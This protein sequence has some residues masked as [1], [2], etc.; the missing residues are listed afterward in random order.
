MASDILVILPSEIWG[1]C[2]TYACRGDRYAANLLLFTSV[3][4]LWFQLLTEMPTLWTNIHVDDSQEDCLATI[5]IFLHLSREAGLSLTVTAPLPKSWSDT[6][7]MVVS[8]RK[9]VRKIS[10]NTNI[11]SHSVGC[12]LR[13]ATADKEAQWTLQHVLKSLSFPPSIRYLDV[14]LGRPCSMGSVWTPP[15]LVSAGNWLL[16]SRVLASQPTTCSSLGALSIRATDLVNIFSFLSSLGQLQR[17][18]LYSEKEDYLLPPPLPVNLQTARMPS[19]RTLRYHGKLH[20]ASSWLLEAASRTVEYLELHI[21]ILDIKIAI[22]SLKKY[23]SLHQLSLTLLLLEYDMNDQNK[24]RTYTQRG[25][26]NSTSRVKPPQWQLKQVQSFHCILRTFSNIKVPDS[27][28]LDHLWHLFQTMFPKMRDLI[29]NLPVQS[30]S[31]FLSL[32]RQKQ[33]RHFE[34]NA[35]ILPLSRQATGFTLGALETL[36]VESI[37][38]LHGLAS[39]NVLYLSTSSSGIFEIPAGVTFMRLRSMH[40]DIRGDTKSSI[41][42][43]GGEFPALK[44]FSIT[45][46]GPTSELIVADFSSLTEISVST[47]LPTFTQGMKFCVALMC[48]PWKCPRLE[49]VNLDSFLEYDVLYMLLLKRNCTRTRAKVS[50]IKRLRLSFLLRIL[51]QTFASLLSGHIPPST[52]SQNLIGRMCIQE[53]QSNLLNENVLGCFCCLQMGVPGCT[54]YLR[55]PSLTRA[56]I[57]TSSANSEIVEQLGLFPLYDWGFP[58][59]L[60]AARNLSADIVFWL[61]SHLRK[62]HLWKS[63]ALV[64]HES[65]Q[66]TLV[67]HKQRCSPTTL[68]TEWDM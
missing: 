33:L 51:R 47:R 59:N 31:L 56:E 60:S 30:R 54:E 43:S 42:L 8:S 21:G 37:S 46:L 18:H 7:S 35:A 48:E 11:D 9:V 12:T 68:L 32:V 66:R 39:A 17:F 55:P 25:I 4:K 22:K 45:F 52:I 44:I 34:S 50:R 10:I 15:Y 1:K 29:W 58:P 27:L 28:D 3:S 20:W 49:Q 16:S 57:N 40:L 6:L 64:W 62:V 67:C 38:A 13:G 65:F 63:T 19:L 26:T 23:G 5:A 36:R 14:D 61:E 2:I 41:D 24:R 53:T